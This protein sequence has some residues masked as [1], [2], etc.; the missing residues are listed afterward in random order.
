MVGSKPGLP[1][2]LALIAVQFPGAKS[3]VKSVMIPPFASVDK[4]RREAKAKL[5][6]AKEPRMFWSGSYGGNLE[7]LRRLVNRNSEVV[8]D[9]YTSDLSQR[10]DK[11]MQEKEPAIWTKRLGI[12]RNFKLRRLPLNREPDLRK[13]NSLLGG[14][15]G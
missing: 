3:P 1:F 15:L 13:A 8:K 4:T 10:V 7:E 6:N 9:A 14:A 2:E 12:C 5:I 11:K